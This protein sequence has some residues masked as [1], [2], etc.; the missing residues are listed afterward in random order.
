MRYLKQENGSNTIECDLCGRTWVTK[1]TID[2]IHHEC[3]PHTKAICVHRGEETRT[4]LCESCSGRIR[5]KVFSCNLHSECTD[6]KPIMDIASCKTCGDFLLPMTIGMATYDDFDGVYFT[7]Q[8]LR[9]YH[10]EA[11]R[12]CEIIVVDNRPDS[13]AG[14]AT[15]TFVRGIGGRYVSMPE[16]TGT[17]QSRNRI[18]EESAAA[19]VLVIDSHVQIQAGALSKLLDYYKANPDSNDLLSGPLLYDDLRSCATHFDDIWRGEMW[20]AWGYDLREKSGDPFPIPGMGLGLFSCRRDAWLGFNPDFRGFGGEEMY[21]H[22][23]YRQSGR[24]CLC[25]PWLRWS[26]RF[27]RPNGVPY[28]CSRESKVRNYILGLTELGIPLDRCREHFLESGMS[29]NE[30]ERLEQQTL[31]E[32]A[33]VVQAD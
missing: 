16:P 28:H 31:S 3:R 8:S 2:R 26:H 10:S 29:L 27:G 6:A 14:E 19:A 33:A 12:D 7:V 21:I 15:K 24:Q 5:L 17:S 30:W 13:P 1:W 9:H 11:L 23:K 32:C 20:G 4:E 25:L 18:F 22:E